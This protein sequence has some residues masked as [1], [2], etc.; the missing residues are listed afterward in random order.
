PD[1]GQDLGGGLGHGPAEQ[2]D[3]AGGGEDQPEKHPPGGGLARPVG[4]EEPEQVALAPLQ[5]EAVDGHQTAEALGQ[6][7]GSDH[8]SHTPAWASSAATRS[9]SGWVT[10]PASA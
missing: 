1:L 7:F 8:R 2:L 6:P 5:V 9:S 3:P 4:P 10:V